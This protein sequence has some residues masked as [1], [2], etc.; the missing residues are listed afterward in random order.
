MRIV[1]VGPTSLPL[2][3][4]Y[5]GAVERRMLELASAQEAAGDTTLLISASAGRD[6][7]RTVRGLNVQD[8][9][10][11]TQRPWR[12]LE[13]LVRGRPAIRAFKPDIVHVHNNWAGAALLKG[14]AGPK[15]LSFDYFEYRGSSKPALRAAYRRALRM[16]DLL[17]PVSEYCRR[18]AIAWWSLPSERFSVLPN[19]VNTD[20]FQPDAERRRAAR[21][22]Y[23]VDGKLVIG[24]VGRVCHQKGSDILVD[25][26]SSVRRT[27]PTAA[28]LVAGPSGQFGREGG[29]ELTEAITAAGG[30]W[31]G[32]V[33]DEELPDVFRALDIFVMP[34]REYEMF[35]MAA[36]EALSC[37]T[38]VVCSDLGGLPEVV[39]AEAGLLVP[40]GD[41]GALA[42]ALTALAGNPQARARHPAALR[43]AVA[44]Y[45]WPQV[46]RAAQ[47]AYRLASSGAKDA[48]PI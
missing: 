32:A 43:G 23:G 30:R 1:H 46:A 7:A 33:S 36:A 38:M 19:G 4:A 48:L 15:V 5:G 13:L 39:P 12:D 25:A 37:G 11:R 21:A 16:F 3:H 45:A 26:F 18:E 29:S 14:V 24:Y 27:H 17:L 47:D 9:R 6:G 20:M 42:G 40:P 41:V 8:V 35:G 2:G 34:T 10:C 28:L 31:L 44:K 22:R